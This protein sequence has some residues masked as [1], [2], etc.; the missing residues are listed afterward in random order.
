[1]ITLRTGLRTSAKKDAVPGR[2]HHL[3]SGTLE[4][5]RSEPANLDGHA[6]KPQAVAA[7]DPLILDRNW[8]Y[9]NREQEKQPNCQLGRNRI[10]FPDE[11]RHYLIHEQ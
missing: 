5:K 10:N 4:Q 3:R 2:T 1:L 8:Q 9:Q 6:Q 7:A 11:S